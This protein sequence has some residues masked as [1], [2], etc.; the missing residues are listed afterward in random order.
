MNRKR[1]LFVEQNTDGT[2][3]GSYHSLLLLVQHL[4]RSAFEPTVA[5]YQDHALV[6]EF[7]RCTAVMML[8]DVKPVRIERAAT[9]GLLDPAGAVALAVQKAVNVTRASAA[10]FARMAQVTRAVRPDLIHMNNSVL[11][12][13]EWPMAARLSRA[14]CVAHQRGFA[15]PPPYIGLFDHIICISE[16]VRADLMERAPGMASRTVRVY[17]GIDIE[18]YV[19]S[20]AGDR[21]ALRREF[22]LR[23]DELVIGLVG[24]IQP[25]KGQ[26]VLLRALPHLQ[27]DKPW[28]CL[29]IGDTPTSSES[30]SYHRHLLDLT[31]SLNLEERVVITGYRSNVAALIS[32]VDILV[33]TSVAPEPFG[34][35]ILEGMALGK[36]VLATDHGGPREIIED[37][38]TGFLLPP[39]DVGV[40]ALSLGRMIDSPRLRATVGAAAAGRVARDFSASESASRV[41]DVYRTFWP[42]MGWKTPRPMGQ[43]GSNP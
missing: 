31:R 11:T 17:N 21:G 20:A 24:N 13:I 4:D 23:N 12:G 42:E 25:W 27:S 43:V 34:R 29:F 14:R 1:I 22:G 38:Q 5:F 8:N 30:E 32:V 33:H 15:P 6:D 3:G 7:E 37:G 36:P 18:D 28:R 41:E 16:A 10:S 19:R 2:V 35:V 9:A 26:D 39:G 40:L